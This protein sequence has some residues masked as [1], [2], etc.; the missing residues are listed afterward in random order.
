MPEQ[1]QAG[2][3]QLLG[4]LSPLLLGAQVGT[5]L[6][7]LGAAGARAVRHRRPEARRCG[8]AACSS[9]R[10]SPRFEKDWSLD[11]TEFRTWI[12]IHEV[13]HRF[14]FARPW[15]L[16]RFRE[17]ID[18]FTSTLTPRRRGAPAAAGVARPVEPR[19]RCRRCSRDEESLFGA[20]MDD[21][22]RLKLGRI[23]A[24]MT[25]AEGYGDHVMHALG[26]QMLPSYARIDEAMRRYR[27]T[28]QRR[29]GLRAAARH[30]GQARAVPARPG[31][32]RHGG[33]ADRRGD[34]RADVGLGGGAAV[35]A[36]ARG[37]ATVARADASE[38]ANERASVGYPLAAMTVGELVSANVVDQR[39][40]DTSG[41]QGPPGVYL[42]GSPGHGAPLRRLP[43]LEGRNGDGDRGDPL[44]RTVR[45]SGAS[46]GSR[47]APHDRQ[48][49]SHR[50]DRHDQRRPFRRDGHLRRLVRD[51]RG[52][53]R[54][55]R[56]SGPG[57]ARAGQAPEADRGRPQA[58]GRDLGR[59]RGERPS[60]A[61]PLVVR[62]PQREDLRA[63]QAR[64]RAGGSDR[65]GHPGR[66]PS[67][68]S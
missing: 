56:G 68:S 15:A 1:A 66:A 46:V 14:E 62:L 24:F 63:V 6:G 26:A 17:L 32:L 21:E 2:V 60:Q 37:A 40:W 11:P 64:A 12:A 27:E 54:R 39:V 42:L 38:P 3:A 55:D 7:T 9:S 33:G 65:A 59:C 31:V 49:G 18:D 50:R 41:E 29:P 20:V 30:R 43:R 13:T 22:Q 34:A 57:P 25:A 44:L 47:G 28:E 67:W 19:R 61:H 58:V 51:R 52:D 5:V 48:H 53:R 35:D 36:R 10:T 8:C 4:Q 45:A 23:Q 16:T